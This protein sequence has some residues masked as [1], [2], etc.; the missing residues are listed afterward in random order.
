MRRCAVAA[1][2]VTAGEY[3]EFL[4]ATGTGRS[5]QPVPGHW[6]DGEPAVPPRTGDSVGLDE[7]ARSPN[8]WAPDCRPSTSGS[9]P[10]RPG[11]GSRRA[12]R[13]C[14]TGPRASTA[15]AS[16]GSSCSRAGRTMPT[17]VGVVLRRRAAAAVSSRPSCCWPDSA[18]SLVVDRIPGGLGSVDRGG[19]RDR[20]RPVPWRTGGPR[21]GDAVRRPDGRDAPRR[22]RRRRHQGR[23]PDAA[24]P[25]ARPRPGPGR[26]R[27]CGGRRSDATS[28]RS[29]STCSPA[30]AR[31]A[32][33]RWPPSADVLIENFRPGH[34]RAVGPRA[35]RAS[36]PRNPRLVIARVTGFGQIGPYA[37]PARVRDARR[38]DERL[39]RDDRRAR[40]TA[41]A[42]AVRSGR[43]RSRRWRRASP[44][45]PP[46]ARGGVRAGSGRRPGDHRADPDD[47]RRRRSPPSTSSGTVQPRTGNRSA[48]NA[49]RNMYRTADGRLG[50][51]QHLAQSI[52]ERVMRLV[53]RPE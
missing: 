43:R 6:V 12:D 15:T 40:R 49:P 3:A 14:G 41:D 53:G 13:S 33:S 42:A 2:E 1:R 21:R 10:P 11:L 35:G 48:N 9:S 31:A 5:C 23:A 34:A 38:G 30:G 32:A 26:R 24:R 36:S 50:G 51:G 27:T 37:S 8:G 4:A 28:G 25:R 29:R 18:W 19:R 22:P 39:R 47:A 45:S 17:G 44:C 7:P 16:P 52:A 20:S 46:C